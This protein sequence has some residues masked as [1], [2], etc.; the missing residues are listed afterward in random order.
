MQKIA[1]E[2][3]LFGISLSP[4]LEYLLIN[5][6]PWWQG[7]PMKPLP[8]F[9]RWLF[10]RVLHRLKSG[11]APVTVLRGA[12]RVGKTTLQEQ[13]IEH[14]LFKENVGANRIFRIQFDELSLFK[15]L[16][17]PILSLCYWFEKRILKDTFNSLAH[18]NEPVYLF[19][20]EV[21]NLPEW[22]RR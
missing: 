9:R 7:N 8:S 12:R 20:D 22:R 14:L 5:T 13:I 11:L 19:F 16:K 1:N 10:D 21:Q 6:N 4:E 3:T 15:G 2:N 18:R 17:E